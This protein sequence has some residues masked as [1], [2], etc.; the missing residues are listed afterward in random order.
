[1]DICGGYCWKKIVK[2]SSYDEKKNLL[3][4]IKADKFVRKVG[5][6]D[7]EED[8]TKKPIGVELVSDQIII[9]YS[10]RNKTVGVIFLK[11]FSSNYSLLP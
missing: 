8:T 5:C 1:M 6:T 7:E 4:S 9:L 10:F 3:N 2:A 11:Q